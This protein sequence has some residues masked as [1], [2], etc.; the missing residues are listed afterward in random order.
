MK[1]RWEP[2]MDID[3][4]LPDELKFY[5]KQ[6]AWY[7]DGYVFTRINEPELGRLALQKVEGAAELIGLIN[8]YGAVRIWLE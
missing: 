1:L 8:L 5:I 3:N 2:A 6:K 7:K 4:I